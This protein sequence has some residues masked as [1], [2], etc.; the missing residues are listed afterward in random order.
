M[1]KVSA[2]LVVF[3]F[4]TSSIIPISHAQG[5][6]KKSTE[7]GTVRVPSSVLNI[8]KENTYPNSSQDMPYLQPS[9]LAKE[10]LGTSKVKIENPNLIRML[11]ESAV[12]KNPLAIGFRATIYLG[13]WPLN[14]ESMETNVNWEYKKVN[15]NF[16][17]NRAG[18][19]PYRV[20]YVQ[21]AQK[22]VKGGLTAR[23]PNSDDVQKMMILKAAEKTKLPLAFSTIVGV[24]TKKENGYNVPAKRVGYLNS[25]TPA[26]SERG[27]VTY[28][29]VFLLLHGSKR[30]IAVKNVTS[31]GIGAW[32][33]VQD[34]L[35][36]SFSVHN[37]PR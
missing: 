29:E 6:N 24:G 27:K 35:S 21:D 7:V 5:T 15:M 16:F 20:R 18:K 8:S 2:L 31:Q 32:I 19:L 26:V 30:T 9:D 1:R 14:Y 12:S 22:Q 10:L 33:P 36:L 34:H 25:Y 13:E 17:D 37:Q 3:L 11:N 23:I 4:F 28:G